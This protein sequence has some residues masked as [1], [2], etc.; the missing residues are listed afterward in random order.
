MRREA[1]TQVITALGGSIT[2]GHSMPEGGKP[3]P[4]LLGEMLRAAFPKSD[5]QVANNAIGATGSDYFDSC[6]EHHTAP[7]TDL[8][9]LEFAVNDAIMWVV[10]FH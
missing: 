2:F 3:W 10:E 7:G 1:L 6:Y 8:F 4:V 5:V 9:L